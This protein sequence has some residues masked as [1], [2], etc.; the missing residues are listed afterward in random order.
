MLVHLRQ[1]ATHF[2]ENRTVR[3][4]AG[5]AYYGIVALVP[6]LVL[7]IAVA[8]LLVGELATS[9]QL[10][11][12]LDGALGE[13]VAELL[14][15]AIVQLDVAGSFTNLTIFSFV[16]LV[17]AASI[18]FVAWKDALNDIWGT[19]ERGGV[20]ESVRE[21]LFAF[22]A[23]GVAGLALTG[24]LLLQ[25]LLAL[26]ESIV[27]DQPVFDF[28]LRLASSSVPLALGTVALALMYR[29]GPDTEVPWRDTWAGT[30]VAVVLLLVSMSVYGIYLSYFGEASATGVAGAAILLIVL[31]YVAAQI[32]LF[33]AEIVYVRGRDS[34]LA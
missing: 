24:I 16:A 20:R 30:I 29:I 8:G 10:Q 7:M 13:K 32:L 14:Q 33:G 28:F 5:L 22:A 19:G 27:P 26:L 15:E 3:L 31:V 11:A 9:G 34:V 18:L 21:R 1:A 2:V 6:L 25:T 12:D 23:V 17:F 4:G